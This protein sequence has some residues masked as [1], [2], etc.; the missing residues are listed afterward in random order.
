MSP[1]RI[2]LCLIIVLSITRLSSAGD[3]F[4]EWR[5]VNGQGHADAVDLAVSW[6]ETENVAWK[7]NVPGRGWS[8]PV[9][10]NGQ[11]WLTT[12]IDRPASKADAAR[13]RKMSTN[14]QPLTISEFVSLRAIGYD[15]K[16]GKLLH[17]IEVLNEQ[18]PQMIHEI[19]TYA[20]PTPIIENGL[21]YC[22]YG[23]SGI[24]CLDTKIGKVLWSNRTLRVKH[25]NGPGSSP[26]LWKNLLIVHCDG[27]DQQYITAL[28]KETG[29][30]VWKT[31]RTG[32]LHENE[33]L[34][35]SYATSL[36]T[37]LNG[38]PQLISPAADWIYG[39]DPATGRELWKQSYGVLGF[40]NSAR[41]VA[42]HSLIFICTGYMKSEMLAIRVDENNGVSKPSIVWRQKKQ[43]PNVSCPLLIGKEIYITSDS[44][45]AT[46]LDALTGEIHW[47]K[48]IGKRYWAS[49]LYADGKI[50]FF[51]RDGATTVIAP[52]KTFKTLSQNQ[53]AGELFAT[54]AA[55]DGALILRTDKAL[56]CIR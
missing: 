53:L 51:D 40:S 42:G 37:V 27:I 20:T 45:V 13:R 26:I 36:V 32:K 8:T 6:S 52:G 9:I 29:K 16:T 43:V 14:S 7:A 46:C 24:A 39:Y 4:P 11:V 10:E 28:D 25:E 34:R 50:Y 22:H 41:P 2:F 18:D 49:P 33:Q 44:G 56:Y 1:Q 30:E 35:K 48:R 17:D 47:S 54:A 55:V 3:R 15:L 31:A 23:P 12:A 5:G 38:K 19:N 21:L